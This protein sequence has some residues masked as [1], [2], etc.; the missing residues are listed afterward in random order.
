MDKKTIQF[1]FATTSATA[2]ISPEAQN[3]NLFNNIEMF[4]L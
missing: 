2:A 4:S 1:L 3:N